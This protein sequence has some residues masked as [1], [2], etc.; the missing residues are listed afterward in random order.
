MTEINFTSTYRIPIKQ[1]GINQAKKDKLVE[2]IESY[3]NGLVGKSKSGNAR[4]SLP[5]SED[6]KFVAKL[7]EIGYSIYQKF[8]GENIDKENL[9]VFIKEKLKT[10]EFSQKGKSPKRMSREMKEERRYGRRLDG[11]KAPSRNHE[12]REAELKSI[13]DQRELQYSK[14]EKQKQA[15]KVA[16]EYRRIKIRKTPA[17]IELAE[18]EGKEFAEAVFFDIR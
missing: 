4:V 15:D 10:R 18:K 13:R 5:N 1:A 3:P 17:Y 9:D 16:E 6:N 11:E 7:K 8:E 14:Y 12:A 2:L